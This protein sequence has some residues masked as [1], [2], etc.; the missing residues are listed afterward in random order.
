MKDKPVRKAHIFTERPVYRPEEA[1]HIKG[2]VRLRK[3]G[4]LIYEEN[5][6]RSLVVEGPGDKKWTYPA[7]LHGDRQFLSQ[8]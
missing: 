1:V 3:M 8:I 7:H 6:R 5:R 2:Y 4:D